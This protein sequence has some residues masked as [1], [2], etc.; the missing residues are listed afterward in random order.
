[1]INLTI[2]FRW[3]ILLA[4]SVEPEQLLHCVVS[5][6]GRHCLP[7]PFFQVSSKT[8][9]VSIGGIFMLFI[10]LFGAFCQDGILIGTIAEKLI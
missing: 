5:D 7:I 10:F 8:G 4:N 9:L 3:K 2:Y 6:P 1:M